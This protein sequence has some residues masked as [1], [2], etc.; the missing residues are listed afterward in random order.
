MDLQRIKPLIKK[1]EDKLEI[2][3]KD[4]EKD[5][6]NLGMSLQSVS[7]DGRKILELTNNLTV[8]FDSEEMPKFITDLYSSNEDIQKYLNNFVGS[9]NDDKKSLQYI[10]SELTTTLD[11]LA[12][13]KT[14]IKTLKMLGISTRIESS[15]LTE[16]GIGFSTLADNVESLSSL[17][18]Q[19]TLNIN[20]KAKELMKIFT[21]SINVM[22]ILIS[23]INET[24]SFIDTE[25]K[26]GIYETECKQKKDRTVI[27]NVTAEFN[28]IVKEMNN[29]IISLQ[30]HDIVRQRNQHIKSAFEELQIHIENKTMN[31]DDIVNEIIQVTELQRIQLAEANNDVQNAV[32]KIIESMSKII[33]SI[34]Q[35]S[36]EINKIMNSSTQEKNFVEQIEVIIKK[37]EEE[38][39]ASENSEEDLSNRINIILLS[40]EQLSQNVLQI[41]DIGEEIELIA[42][43]ARVKAARVGNNGAAL[44]VIS[45]AIQ[46]LS[47]DSRDHIKSIS[48]V[49]TNVN[50]NADKLKE[51]TNDE[52]TSERRKYANQ[53]L[54]DIKSIFDEISEIDNNIKMSMN[55][56]ESNINSLMKEINSRLISFNGHKLFDDI[57]TNINTFIQQIL[58]EVKPFAIDHNLY[59][60]KILKKHQEKY[61]MHYERNI[62]DA[63]NNVEVINQTS[64]DGFGDNVEL[65]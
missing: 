4:S 61:T 41:E 29:V 35:I 19:K 13:F 17:I 2:L 60:S 6:I 36:F 21:D 15:R 53:V 32:G 22:E 26:T 11:K 7:T 51:N 40:I 27:S 47:V 55:D 43:N 8:K 18:E 30:F 31:D 23:Q 64:N 25:I 39:S 38:F 42:L 46:K 48:Q 28:D 16:E 10:T 54:L 49:L 58:S 65:F 44:G 52:N 62:H 5:F 37:I 20:D 1:I 59:Q 45:E 50:N 12:G 57:T 33:K 14:I 63:Y 24:I 3:I 9:T 56:I 34:E